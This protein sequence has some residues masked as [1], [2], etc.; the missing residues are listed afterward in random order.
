[1]SPKE[2]DRM[3]ERLERM[4]GIMWRQTGLSDYIKDLQER[5]EKLEEALKT[6]IK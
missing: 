2:I 6:G 3:F 4:E 5:I 1:M